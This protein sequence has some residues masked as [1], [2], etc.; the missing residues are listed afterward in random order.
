MSFDSQK[1]ISSVTNRILAMKFA[2]E[3]ILIYPLITIMYGA[4][5]HV[6]AAGIG[7][8]LALGLALSVIFEIPTGIIADKVP[9]KYVLVASVL[10]KILALT[11]WLLLPYFRGYL[12]AAI[13]FALSTA[14]ESGTLQAYLYGTLGDESKRNFGKFWARLSAMV[15]ISYTVAYVFTTIVGI[16]YPLLLVLSIVPPVIALFICLSLPVD[17]LTPVA[18]EVKPKIFASAVKHIKGSPD[19]IKLIVSGIIV[20]ALAEV[21]IEYLSLYYNQVG[22]SVR[23]VPIMMAIGNTVGAFLFWTLHAWE[24]TLDKY[25]LILVMIAGILFVISFFGGVVIATVGVLLFTRFIRVLQV[26]YESNVQHLSSDQARATISSIGNFA[27]SLLGASIFATIGLT[28]I[29]NSILQPIRVS[30]L[31]GIFAYL[32]LQLF[33]KHRLNDQTGLEPK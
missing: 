28:A 18:G 5:G 7:I 13:L 14:F 25:K 8:I 26:Q 20:V 15:M 32:V 16:N 11:A 6:N 21:L 29:N 31:V 2:A 23:F 22:I 17:R 27:A 19:L 1:F 10:F 9:R 12:L 30:L 33:N 24:H 3:F 4:H